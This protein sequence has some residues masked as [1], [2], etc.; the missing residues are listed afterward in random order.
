MEHFIYYCTKYAYYTYLP[1]NLVID[2]QKSISIQR[3]L[4]L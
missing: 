1:R 3:E 2:G 4:W